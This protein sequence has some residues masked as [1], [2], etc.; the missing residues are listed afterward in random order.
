MTCLTRSCESGLTSEAL[1]DALAKFDAEIVLIEPKI[2]LDADGPAG[3]D[4]TLSTWTND[5]SHLTEN[6]EKISEAILSKERAMMRVKSDG[7]A[8]NVATFVESDTADGPNDF[9]GLRVETEDVM[10]RRSPERFLG[11]SNSSKGPKTATLKEF[12]LGSHLVAW[13]LCPTKA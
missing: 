10:T 2:R 4:T 1:L 11:E 8:W 6:L 5:L 3:R 12:W 7:D 13:W 9:S